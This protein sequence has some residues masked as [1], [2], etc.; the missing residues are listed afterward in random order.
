MEISEKTVKFIMEHLKDDPNGLRLKYSGKAAMMDIPI[1]FAL[2]QIE[3]RRKAQKKIPTYIEDPY[4]IFPD[5]LASE[6]ATNEIIAQFHSSLVNTGSTILDLTAGLGIDDMTFAKNGMTV[7]ACEIDGKKSEALTHN[8]EIMGLKD[9]LTVINIDSMNYVRNCNKHYDI[10]F[11]DP[12]RRSSNGRR[13]HALSDCQPDILEGMDLIMQLTDRLL[14]K[15]SPLLDLTL[16]RD[17]VDNLSH[18]Y[19]VCHKGECKEVLIDIRKG[20]D[21]SGVTVVDLD[22]KGMISTFECRFSP[23]PDVAEFHNDPVLK[24]VDRQNPMDYRYIYEPNAGIMKTGA[25]EELSQS[26]PDLRKADQNTHIFFS[27]TLFRHFPGRTLAIRSQ[28]NKKT[29][30]EMKGKKCN[31]VERNYPLSAPEI[32]KKYSLIPGGT[33]YLYALRYQGTPICL[34]A[35]LISK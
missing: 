26:F 17:T 3:A 28:L 8:V 31:I 18:I 11:S 22:S 13:L 14:I 7:T 30:K 12:A 4:F 35:D 24:Y 16:I 32:A 15:S 23:T 33:N 34:L 6:Q 10:V 5:T 9:R 2:L 20:S 29:L 1:D 19:V 21:F 27:D 25:W